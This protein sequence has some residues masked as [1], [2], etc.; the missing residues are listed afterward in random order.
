MHVTAR[1]MPTATPAEAHARP[2]GSVLLDVRGDDEW[3]AGHAPGA[4]HLPM[5][6]VTPDRLLPRVD[7]SH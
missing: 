1:P 7:F 6:R 2:D 4:V 5:H 3:A